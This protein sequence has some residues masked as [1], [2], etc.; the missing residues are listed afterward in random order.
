MQETPQVYLKLDRH[1]NK[2]YQGAS[3]W[4]P[5]AESVMDLPAGTVGAVPGQS[6][7]INAPQE[8]ARMTNRFSSRL[9]GRVFK[10]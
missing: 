2:I 7:P 8:L 3:V 9:V 4:G 10:P 5:E 1:V 6:L